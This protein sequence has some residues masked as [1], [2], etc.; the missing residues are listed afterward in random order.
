M[1]AGKRELRFFVF[2]GEVCKI[3]SLRREFVAE[4]H[5]VVEYAKTYVHEPFCGRVDE[6]HQKFVVAI[7]YGCFLSPDW[8]P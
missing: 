3:P 1:V 8:M 7:F 6:M 5:A 4:A 2:D